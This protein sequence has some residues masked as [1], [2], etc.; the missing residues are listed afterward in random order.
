[1]VIFRIKCTL[2]IFSHCWWYIIYTQIF[3]T[4][5]LSNW[6]FSH[7]SGWH[8]F[9]WHTGPLNTE[10]IP[11]HAFKACRK[12]LHQIIFFNQKPSF[13]HLLRASER[14]NKDMGLQPLNRKN[15]CLALYHIKNS[16]KSIFSAQ[17]E[18]ETESAETIKSS[19]ALLLERKWITKQR[20]WDRTERTACSSQTDCPSSPKDTALCTSRWKTWR[21]LAT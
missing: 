16:L 9:Q 11:N 10:Q 13:G 17:L 8:Y 20:S 15:E 1:M 21:F 3:I 6:W 14:L 4:W 5:G 7:A 19:S 12:K 2:N 18:T